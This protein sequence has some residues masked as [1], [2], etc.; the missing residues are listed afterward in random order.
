MKNVTQEICKCV[1]DI[2]NKVLPDEVVKETKMHILDYYAACFAGYRVNYE[3]NK[4]NK[5][6]YSDMGGKQEATV[7]FSNLR[8]PACNAAY[9]NALYAHGADMDDGNSKAAGHIAAHVIP[10]VFAVAESLECSWNEVFIAINTGY[11][12]FNRIAGAAQPYLYKKGFH[13]TGVV[14]GIACAAACS[15]LLGLKEDGLYN[16]VSLAAIQ[17]SGLIII[18]E[19]GQTCKPINPANAAKNGVLCAKLAQEGVEAPRNPLESSKGWFNAFSQLQ[20]EQNIISEWGEK[21]SITESYIK[22][23][24]TC[25]HTHSCIEA[26]CEIHRKLKHNCNNIDDIMKIKIYIYSSAIRSA[27]NIISPQNSHEAKFSIAYTV[28]VSLL[29]GDFRLDDIINVNQSEKVKILEK[30]VEI[31]EDETTFNS[32]KISRGCKMV[33]SVKQGGEYAQQV[34][35]PRGEMDKKLTWNELSKKLYQC[36]MKVASPE[37]NSRIVDECRKIKMDNRFT[38]LNTAVGKE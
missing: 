27:G 4:V 18:D 24:P 26:A 10:A 14:G 9:L 7:L 31:L 32:A 28:A 8:I 2:H 36:S 6:I 5:L 15:Q 11:D 25:R 17:S 23:Y 35:Y 30:K 33:V 19:S 37:E 34:D 16:A 1:V 21:Y 20:E 13:S 3:F 29:N 38:F 12:F 22:K